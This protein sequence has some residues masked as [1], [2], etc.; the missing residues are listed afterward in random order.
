MSNQAVIQAVVLSPTKTYD[1]NNYTLN[2]SGNPLKGRRSARI[3]VP[4][5]GDKG[6]Q[7]DTATVEISGDEFNA[8]WSSF[9]SDKQIVDLVMKKQGITQD[10]T[11]I[12]DSIVNA[13]SKA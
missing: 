7:I 3:S 11:A 12:D 8:F 10:V 9:T 4:V 1:F 6:T 13:A 2:V 5:L